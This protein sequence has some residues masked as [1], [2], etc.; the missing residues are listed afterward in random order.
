MFVYL[1]YKLNYSVFE[2]YLFRNVAI[3]RLYSIK[4]MIIVFLG[5]GIMRAT[6]T[7]KSTD[8]VI[9]IFISN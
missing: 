8:V 7:R 9:N 2:H 6:Y 4:K 5:S 3:D 1:F